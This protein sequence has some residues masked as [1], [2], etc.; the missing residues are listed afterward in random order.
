MITKD[1]AMN[2]FLVVALRRDERTKQEEERRMTLNERKAI[3]AFL[4]A[5]EAEARRPLYQLPC[6]VTPVMAESVLSW[7]RGRLNGSSTSKLRRS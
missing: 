5:A 7:L 6:P 1:S 4:D 3:E 2:Q